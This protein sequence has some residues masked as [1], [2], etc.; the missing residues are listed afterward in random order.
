MTTHRRPSHDQSLISQTLAGTRFV[1]IAGPV[2]DW[3]VFYEPAEKVELTQDLITAL[4]DRV[5]GVGASG[6]VVVTSTQSTPSGTS[7]QYRIDAWQADGQPAHNMIEPARAA[8]CVLAVL[9]RISAHETS[10]HVF[11]TNFGPATTVYTPSY[12]GV[13]I[14]QWSFTEPETADAAGSDALVMAAG[15]TDPRPGLS[16]NV[17]SHHV[18]IAVETIQE[19]EAIDLTQRPSVEPPVNVPTSMSFVVPQDPLIE[20]GMGQLRLRNYTKHGRDQN[21]A[22]AT[23]AATVAFQNWSG[24][25]QLNVWNVATEHG[26]IVVQIHD[27]HRLSTFAKLSSVFFGKL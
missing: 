23:A 13:D 4:C 15:L 8:T 10:H 26:D 6:V 21:L 7:P 19:L 11:E 9:N 24:L 2:G 16:I 27:Q 1:K 3:I 20:E 25:K 5:A 22:S 14:G 17:Q 18:T 12:V